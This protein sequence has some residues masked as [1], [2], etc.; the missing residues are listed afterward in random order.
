MQNK[1]YIL[2][3]AIVFLMALAI[4][5]M[6]S[7]DTYSTLV[8]LST[9][10]NYST[11]PTFNCTTRND[12]DDCHT[13]T[14]ATIFYNATGGATTG[15]AGAILCNLV[16]QSDDLFGHEEFLSSTNSAC[17]SAWAS[18]TDKDNTPGYNFSCVFSNASETYIR[19]SSS[20]ATVGVDQTDP[21]V[22]ISSTYS[23]VNLGRYFQYTISLADATTGLLAS[24]ASTYCN[25][26]DAEDV[27]DNDGVISTSASSVEFTHTDV[28]GDYVISCTAT[29]EA[30]NSATD[31]LTVTAKTSGAPIV[32]GG[33]QGIASSLKDLDSKTIII[34]IIAI[35]L[36][37]MAMGKK[38]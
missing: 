16:N 17:A 31:T 37:A 11:M 21:T 38:K 5:P 12:S 1:K 34:V 30:G 29:D 26:T 20:V 33:E 24:T 32:I 23:S 9:G 18:L 4:V 7:S 35:V 22:T 6:V 28:A 10:Y 25:M 2:P 15:T 36:I 14:N 19:N 13:C 27:V 3:I 8:G